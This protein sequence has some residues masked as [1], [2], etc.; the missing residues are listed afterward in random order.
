MTIAR[1]IELSH[2][3][4]NSTNNSTSNSTDD[5]PRYI[6]LKADY[7]FGLLLIWT[8]F[9][10]YYHVF[11]GVFCLRKG[12][13]IIYIVSTGIVWAY[14]TINYIESVQPPVT[15]L[16]RLS[17]TTVIAPIIIALGIH[18]AVKYSSNNQL[19]YYTVGPDPDDQSRFRMVLLHDCVIKFD[20]QMTGR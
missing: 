20:L 16:I 10:A 5:L 19:I 11:F 8:A 18:L 15:K 2:D 7:T 4:Q 6:Q 12:D 14:V 9:F 3:H 13:I 17:I 1:I